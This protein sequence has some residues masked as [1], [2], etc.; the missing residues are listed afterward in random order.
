MRMSTQPK[1]LPDEPFPPQ[2]ALDMAIVAATVALKVAADH[3]D[4]RAKEDGYVSTL[5]EQIRRD[6]DNLEAARRRARGVA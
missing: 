4:A 2:L 6:A 5:A 1:G 3:L